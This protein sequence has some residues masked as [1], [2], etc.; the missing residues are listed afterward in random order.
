MTKMSGRSIQ[1]DWEKILTTAMELAP[2]FERVAAS[3]PY[4]AKGV[5]FSEVLF[6]LAATG[7][8]TPQTVFESGRAAGVSTFL[9]STC[10][11][12]SKIVSI[13]RDEHSPDVG[14]ATKNLKGLANVDCRFGDSRTL[15]LEMVQPADIVVIDG[16]KEYRAL[17][18]ALTLLWQRQPKMVFIHDCYRGSIER[19]FLDKNVPGCLFSDQKEF[20]QRYRKFDA[21]CWE[22]TNS[23]IR[24]G[25]FIPHLNH[26]KGAS[27]G[28]TFAC[29]PYN[30]KLPFRKLL[31]QLRLA[32]MLNRVTRSVS[33]KL[34]QKI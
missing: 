1:I 3:A 21:K 14:L 20:V 5:L 16:P 26:G 25:V 29:L 6:V 33:K 8:G 28:P 27:Y 11:P 12:K 17:R 34:A 4:E 32:D 9:L 31:F 15:L 30:P 22:K 2:D 19:H 10:F 24:E 7:T 13:E 18:L 23:M